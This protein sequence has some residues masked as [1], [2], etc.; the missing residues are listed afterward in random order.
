[1]GCL[2]S[3]FLYILFPWL[4]SSTRPSARE[5]TLDFKGGQPPPFQR[6]QMLLGI[7]FRSFSFLSQNWE[8]QKIYCLGFLGASF[9]V[10]FFP[11]AY[12]DTRLRL[13][14]HSQIN[15]CEGGSPS[16]LQ[17]NPTDVKMPWNIALQFRLVSFCC[18]QVTSKLSFV[19]LF[20]RIFFRLSQN[21][22]EFFIFMM[23]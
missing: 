15:I 6:N 21:S 11:R 19:W 12:S 13:G 3:M 10:I 7:S 4:L 22:L 20:P 8:T 9:S 17:S 14:N 1:M 23:Q 5:I 2:G 16:L 18:C